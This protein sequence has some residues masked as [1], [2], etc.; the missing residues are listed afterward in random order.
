M[1][2]FQEAFSTY[3]P[4]S[5]Q[6][7]AASVFCTVTQNS[8][9]A[10]KGRVLVEGC[11]C[12]EAPG[13]CQSLPCRMGGGRAHPMP[14]RSALDFLPPSGA[15]KA[16]DQF[17]NREQSHLSAL[18]YCCHRIKVSKGDQLDHPSYMPAILSPRALPSSLE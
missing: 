18:R 5:L 6:R 1:S 14:P 16:G 3:L 7:S 9:T 10:A 17:E 12:R 15:P 4:C 2:S 11:P 8:F 13:H